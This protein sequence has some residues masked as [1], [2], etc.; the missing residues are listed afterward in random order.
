M[1]VAQAPAAHLSRAAGRAVFGTDAAGYHASRSGYPEDLYDKVFARVV[2]RPNILEIAAGTG[3][4]T[5]ALLARDP[6]AL[7]VVES[8]PEL[9]VFLKARFP[10]PRVTVINANFPD[11]ALDGPF[12]LITCAAAFHWMEPESALTRAQAL[13]RPGG[14][15]AMWWNSYCNPGVGDRFAN[16]VYPMLLQLELPPSWTTKGHYGLDAAHQIQTLQAG[17]FI[18]V[19]SHSYRHERMLSET[20]IRALYE[21]YSFIRLLPAEERAALFRS[22]AQIVAQDF[23]K[24]PDGEVPNVTLTALYTAAK[25]L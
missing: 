6:A 15:W 21:T 3:L 12:D 7:V 2:S 18:D 22:F 9:A 23:A 4:A 1:T 20:D 13:L 14:I 11:V 24:S 5:E 17:R 10:D 16:S 8:D 25:S 19:E